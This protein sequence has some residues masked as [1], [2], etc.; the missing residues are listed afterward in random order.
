[1]TSRQPSSAVRGPLQERHL[2][3]DPI[4]GQGD[5]KE[6]TDWSGLVERGRATRFGEDWSGQRCGAKTRA[7]SPCKRPAIMQKGRCRLH[8]GRSTGPRSE[9]GRAR[10]VAAN[11]KHGQRTKEK[12]SENRERAEA[13]RE[14]NFALRTQTA[15]MIKQGFLPKGWRP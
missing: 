12:L 5:S 6:N 14:I 9:E 10:I 11:L 2:S 7:G 1:M 8:G 13:H 15:V 4:N 3:D